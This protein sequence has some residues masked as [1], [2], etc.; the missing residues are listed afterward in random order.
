MSMIRKN[1]T[2]PASTYKTIDDYAKKCGKSFS[3]FLRETALKAIDESEKVSLIE[4]IN[5]NCEYMDKNEQE[6]VEALNI[7]FDD[8]SG[9]ELT[10]DELL[11]G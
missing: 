2:L 3:E 8:L 9:R 10:L 11:Q 5:A 6:K 1:I 7:D 4:Y